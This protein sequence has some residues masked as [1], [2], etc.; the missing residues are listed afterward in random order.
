MSGGPAG[1]MPWLASQPNNSGKALSTAL[2]RPSM[3]TVI[4]MAA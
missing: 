2:D 3:G 1:V 4:G